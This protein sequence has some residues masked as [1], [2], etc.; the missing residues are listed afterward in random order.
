MKIEESVSE[1]KDLL[2]LPKVMN[3]RQDYLERKIA[4]ALI[5][6]AVGY[7]FGEE[8]RDV[9]NGKLEADQVNAGLL[10]EVPKQVSANRKW[11]VYSDLFIVL[12]QKLRQ[13]EKMLVTIAKSVTQIFL[14]LVYGPVRT[15]D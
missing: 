10:G 2:Y 4:L 5:A 11:Q 14:I 8:V 1:C 15:F 9:C 7:L 6:Y 3:E 13:P 12:T